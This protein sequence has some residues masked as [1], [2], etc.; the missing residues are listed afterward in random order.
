MTH[1]ARLEKVGSLKSVG[2]S[3]TFF[4]ALRWTTPEMSLGEVAYPLHRSTV[5][6][7]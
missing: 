2:A 7:C 3:M 6:S 5:H 1:G 4:W